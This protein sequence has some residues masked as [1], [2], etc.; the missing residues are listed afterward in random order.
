IENE[1][2]RQKSSGL[3]LAKRE[4]RLLVLRGGDAEGGDKTMDEAFTKLKG[5]QGPLQEQLRL[6]ER[7][8]QEARQLYE[9]S[10]QRRKA[11]GQCVLSLDSFL[12]AAATQRTLLERVNDLRLEADRFNSSSAVSRIQMLRGL[13]GYVEGVRERFVRRRLAKDLPLMFES[14]CKLLSAG[15]QVEVSVREGDMGVVGVGGAGD[16]GVVADV[17]AGGEMAVEAEEDALAVVPVQ[18]RAGVET[19]A[20]AEAGT[21]AEAGGEVEEAGVSQPDPMSLYCA[22]RVGLETV[23]LWRQ[24][25][26]HNLAPELARRLD[27]FEAHLRGT[28]LTQAAPAPTPEGRDNATVVL[29]FDHLQHDTPEDHV[30]HQSRVLTCM[31]TLSDRL[32]VE[33]QGPESESDTDTDQPRRS[34]RSAQPGVWRGRALSLVRCNDILCPPMW[35]L[36]LAHSP[37]YLSQLWRLADEATVNDLFVPLEFDTEWIDE[38]P[39][40]ASDEE[41]PRRGAPRSSDLLRRMPLDEVGQEV[42]GAAQGA[43]LD[44]LTPTEADHLVAKVI[45]RIDAKEAVRTART[46][47]QAE[48]AK[49]KQ[50][51]GEKVDGR[52]KR[53]RKPAGDVVVLGDEEVDTPFGQG[54]IVR[55]SYRRDR[56]LTVQLPWGQAH[57]RAECVTFTALGAAENQVR[58]MERNSISAA[59]AFYISGSGGRFGHTD[60]ELHNTLARLVGVLKVQ[61]TLCDLLELGH[62]NFSL[63]MHGRT[64]AGLTRNIE[65]QIRRWVGRHDVSKMMGVVARAEERALEG[66]A[67][68]A[69]EILRVVEDT[70]TL[71]GRGRGVKVEAVKVEVGV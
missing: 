60:L 21:D 24:L 69:R 68:D 63:Y 23:R 51:K 2:A 52:T 41:S 61:K 67:M 70:C 38:D 4:E 1:S 42:L 14:L 30:E 64:S 65:G 29:F 17:G 9:A 34:L 37:Q 39:Y 27:E 71:P 40:Q 10:I 20:G 44:L 13:R 11:V 50:E 31:K 46:A 15:G 58:K 45:R 62:A 25:A 32:A 56:L 6:A 12:V 28:L 19:G 16:V 18:E 55:T 36:P 22:S 8:E 48:K 47:K 3:A 43:F 26:L 57:L 66:R 49:E 54:H 5:E 35:C 7:Q 53:G 59:Q 33:P